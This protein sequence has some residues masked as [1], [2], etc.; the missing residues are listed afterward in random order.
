VGVGEANLFALASAFIEVVQKTIKINTEKVINAARPK[1]VQVHSNYN[2]KM[3]P[4][5]VFWLCSESAQD[6]AH[7]HTHF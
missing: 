5:S 3:A 6:F 1:K 7:T 4:H 2:A